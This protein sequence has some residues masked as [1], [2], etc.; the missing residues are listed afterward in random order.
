[1]LT[2]I[3]IASNHIY[4][5][6]PSFDPIFPATE[7]RYFSKE[8]EPYYY[9][10]DPRARVLACADATELCSPDGQTCWSMTMPLPPSVPNIPSYWFMKWSLENSNTYES[11]K[12]RLGSALLAQESISQSVSKPLP[13]NQWELEAR[14]FFAASL[15]RIQYDAWGI[16]RGEDHD[17][18]G[19]VEVTPAEAQGQLCR[20]YKFNSIGYTNV[21]LLGFIGLPLA[22]I[23]VWI[24]SWEIKTPVT[25]SGTPVAT[26]SG[27][28]ADT[29]AGITGG[30]TPGMTPGTTTE[31]SVGTTPNTTASTR[32]GHSGNVSHDSGPMVID[33]IAKFVGFR[34]LDLIVGICR[35]S[36]RAGCA[37]AHLWKNRKTGLMS[38]DSGEG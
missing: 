36:A 26:A 30:T 10:S 11:I 25:K 3:F 31:I 7:P 2:I 22:A 9:N 15:A 12:W 1:T 19:Y 17:R 35:Y 13:N 29:T 18:P 21:N 16:A 28:N 4:H 6:K 37:I 32:S 24:L 34:I 20:L 33:I 8:R 5:E 14:Q 23:V 38:T 27:I